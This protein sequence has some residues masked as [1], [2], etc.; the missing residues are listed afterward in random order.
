MTK[1]TFGIIEAPESKKAATSV[2][3]FT[4]PPTTGKEA[5]F[6]EAMLNT[7]LNGRKKRGLRSLAKKE[8]KHLVLSALI[9]AVFDGSK[10]PFWQFEDGS[11]LLF[12]LGSFD[13][14]LDNFLI[15]LTNLEDEADQKDDG[16]L[17]LKGQGA[18]ED[19]QVS[20]EGDAKN[21]V[22]LQL[23]H[24]ELRVDESPEKS[25][26]GA[27]EESLGAAVQVEPVLEPEQEEEEEEESE[28]D[29]MERQLRN[30][31]G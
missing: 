29:R 27:G 25:L 9:T 28:M 10:K 12:P 8:A 4:F 6:L 14:S 22:S 3:P 13:G 5:R 18:E 30:S 21:Q 15:A 17:A 31:R 11:K 26:Q 20:H 16:D 24:D 23:E 19:R 2:E 1:L 7:L